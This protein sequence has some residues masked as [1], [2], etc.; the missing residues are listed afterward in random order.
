MTTSYC[1][2]PTLSGPKGVPPFIQ[3]LSRSRRIFSGCRLYVHGFPDGAVAAVMTR[4][5]AVAVA[6]A[7]ASLVPSLHDGVLKCGVELF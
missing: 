6:R 1:S 5:D 7:E 2:G 3:V 4:E